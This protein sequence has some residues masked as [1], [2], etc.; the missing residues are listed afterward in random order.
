MLRSEQSVLKMRVTTNALVEQ[1]PLRYESIRREPDSAPRVTSCRG[2][3]TV[4]ESE[5]VWEAPW[6]LTLALAAPRANRSG[7]GASAPR[8]VAFSRNP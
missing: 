8:F 4:T 2:W 7:P 5:S 1:L 3:L 6:R